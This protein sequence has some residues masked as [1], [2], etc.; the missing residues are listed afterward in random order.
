MVSV[1]MEAKFEKMKDSY[2]GILKF[3]N[4][5]CGHEYEEPIKPI[6]S[7]TQNDGTIMR[8]RIKPR[9]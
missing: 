7:L 5:I 1:E 8:F 4:G 6:S 2:D 3:G 9:G